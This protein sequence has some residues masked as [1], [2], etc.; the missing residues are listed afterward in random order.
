V[1]P[2][3]TAA[4]SRTPAVAH[5]TGGSERPRTHLPWLQ[6]WPPLPSPRGCQQ[7]AARPAHKGTFTALVQCTNTKLHRLVQKESALVVPDASRILF[8]ISQ[9]LLAG[10]HVHFGNSPGLLLH[11]TK[12][13]IPFVR[14][15]HRHVP[16][17]TD[18]PSL[19]S[20]RYIPTST[21][22]VRSSTGYTHTRSLSHPARN[23]NNKIHRQES[24]LPNMYHSKSKK[25]RSPASIRRCQTRS[26]PL[27]RCIGRHIRQ[28]AHTRHFQRVLLHTIHVQ[29]LLRKDG[30]ICPTQKPPH[31]RVP[32]V[33]RSFR[34]HTSSQT[35]H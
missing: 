28:N 27:A 13:F 14:D 4:P 31:S 18:P 6:F 12:I 17:A 2:S 3:P 21:S 8:S 20:Q 30:R 34:G 35:T 24:Y 16:V 33:R 26:T 29:F 9:A 25:D 7:S 32:K 19:S 15:S 11:N 1:L 23:S 10:H 5:G 22:N